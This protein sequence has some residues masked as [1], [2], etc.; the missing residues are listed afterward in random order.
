M[1]VKIT[2]G[3]VTNFIPPET[4]WEAPDKYTVVVKSKNPWPAVYDWLEVVGILDKETTEGPDSK[5]RAV[6]TGPFTF[7]EWVQGSHV[8]YG[9]N[10]SYWQTGRPYLDGIRVSIMRDQQSMVAQLESGALDLAMTPGLTDF[11]PSRR[12]PDS[13][14]PVRDRLG[15]RSVEAASPTPGACGCR[16]R[17]T[18]R[19]SGR[20]SAPTDERP[21]LP[22]KPSPSVPASASARSS[23]LKP[24]AYGR[25]VPP[26]CS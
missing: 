26:P 21:G 19:R 10:P 4:T 18:R 3:I 16:S 25:A 13:G 14:D 6:G 9:K 8:A 24:V 11:V 17:A 22:R 7:F 2:A 12:G 20:C 5:T 23:S 1:D 15:H